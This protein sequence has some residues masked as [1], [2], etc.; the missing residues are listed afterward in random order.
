[1]KVSF[2]D[3]CDIQMKSSWTQPVDII[4]LSLKGEGRV[5]TEVQASSA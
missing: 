1:M 3:L 4:G 2:G 5:E